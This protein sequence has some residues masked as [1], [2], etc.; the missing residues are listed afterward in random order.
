[1]FKKISTLIILS[2]I[3]Y[4]CQ[5]HLVPTTDG[6]MK[7]SIISLQTEAN[8]LYDN[9][10]INSTYDFSAPA[11]A[12]ISAHIDSIRAVDSTRKYAKNVFK[13]V[14]LL[15]DAFQKY[16]SQHQ[17]QGTASRYYIAQWKA[18][19]LSFISPVLTS[20]MSY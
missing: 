18:Y 9:A 2:I 3:M 15:S 13:E 8:S 10:L 6:K 19:L 20:E 16:R 4:S 11:Y 14:V 7:A 5:V 1:M 17:Q 12:S